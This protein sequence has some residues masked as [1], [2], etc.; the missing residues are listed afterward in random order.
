MSKAVVALWNVWINGIPLDKRR[1]SNV[2]SIDIVEQCDGSDTLTLVVNDPDFLYIEDNIFIDEATIKAEIYFQ[3]D[4]HKVNFDGYISAI[5][6]SF[7]EDGIPYLNIFCLDRSHIMNRVKKKRSW[8]NTT[9]CDV[10][11][12]IAGEYGFRFVTES[13]Y[14]FQV[15][16]SI[17]QSNV[18]DIAFCENLAGEEIEPFM[19]KLVGDT[20]YYVKKGT[21]DT[22]SCTL[23]YRRFPYDVVSFSPKIN[24][25]TKSI[26]V[27]SSDV[28]TSNKSVVSGSENGSNVS[29]QGNATNNGSVPQ[30]RYNPKTQK[31]EVV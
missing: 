31:W 6:I 9:R 24:K 20:L 7:P 18:T 10:A 17:Q 30:Y 27:N 8:E 25:E 28:N 22:P 16:D 26:E 12:R 3:G 15:E 19:C 1:R 13:G 21:L 4:T 11:R 5:D 2:D 14:Y 23:N 29:N